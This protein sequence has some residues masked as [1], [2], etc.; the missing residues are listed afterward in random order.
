MTAKNPMNESPRHSSATEALEGFDHL[1][2]EG[3]L[4]EALALTRRAGQR[5]PD[6]AALLHAQGLALWGLGKFEQ[7]A[8]CMQ[9]A[10]A[11]DTCPCEARLDLAALLV[12]HLG[13]P[14]DALQ[15]LQ[16][17]RGLFSEAAYRAA[18]H[19]LRGRAY[20]LQ[21]DAHA[22]VKE[23]REARSHQ[24]DDADLAVE[25]AGMELEA[26]DLDGA[27]MTLAE[28]SELDPELAQAHW[29]RALLLDRRGQSEEALK[30]FQEAARLSPEDC[31]VPERFTDKE[32][33]LH[34]ETALAGI[35]GSFRQHLENTELAVES[36]PSDQLARHQAVSPW[37]LGLFL[38]TPLT[39]RD[40][41]HADL[42]P[43]ILIFQ[44]NLENVC[45]TREELVHEIGITVRHEIGHLLGMDEEAIEDAGHR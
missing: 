25:L 6:D 7:A 22:A 31:F 2:Q 8:E 18:A 27:A 1:Y 30:A 41:E 40:L 39:H 9:Q 34:V 29:L 14:A 44:R 23:L 42:P 16:S 28:A 33:E 11:Q 38:G 10:T 24:L 13:C 36:H 15:L 45:R 35:P 5:F 19:A 4:E 21:E 12:D 32:F 3:N 17:P 37:I 43:R 20:L 26:L